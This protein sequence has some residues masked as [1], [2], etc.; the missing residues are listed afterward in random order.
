[1]TTTTQYSL[2]RSDTANYGYVVSTHRTS[3]AAQAA[4]ERAARRCPANAIVSL[5]YRVAETTGAKRG[6]RIRA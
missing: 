3:D 2:I 5:M 4:Y 6:Q 1:M